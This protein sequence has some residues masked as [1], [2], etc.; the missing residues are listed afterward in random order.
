M[1][2]LIDILLFVIA[3]S[4]VGCDNNKSLVLSETGEN[5]D[6]TAKVSSI[7]EMTP[8]GIMYR[9]DV[10]HKQRIK[11]TGE[12]YYEPGYHYIKMNYEY[13]KEDEIYKIQV[14]R[15][16]G[17]ACR[18]KLSNVTIGIKNKVSSEFNEGRY[19]IIPITEIVTFDGNSPQRLSGSYQD[20]DGDVVLDKDYFPMV[21]V[22]RDEGA[23]KE[24]SFVRAT[25]DVIFR[26]KNT[27][28]IL[29]S[30]RIH[31]AKVIYAVEPKVH[32][33]G[34]YISVTYPDGTTESSPFFP[35][36]K[37]IQSLLKKDN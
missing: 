19:E 11:S 24:K 27:K 1:K 28:N 22:R 16:G 30:P 17:G 37:K 29:F 12:T 34:D 15:F 8:L 4:L 18:W 13:S 25:P 21:T 33:L 2:K 35:D 7:T 10:C 26:T 36:Y 6:I 23:L 5:V 20:I 31:L 14:P 32:K 3:V 9:S